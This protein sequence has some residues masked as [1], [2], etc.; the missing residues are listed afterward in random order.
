MLNVSPGNV[1]TAILAL[2]T[3]QNHLT[4]SWRSVREVC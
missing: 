1:Y 4:Q 3:Y 2:V